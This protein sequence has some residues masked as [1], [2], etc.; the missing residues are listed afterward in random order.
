MRNALRLAIFGMLGIWINAA[1]AKE[2]KNFLIDL[3]GGDGVQVNNV[4]IHQGHFETFSLEDLSSLNDS[5]SAASQQITGG[6]AFQSVTYNVAT[7]VPVEEESLGPTL[8]ERPQTIG[9]QRLNTAASFTHVDFK[10]FKGNKLNNTNITAP[11]EDVC[12]PPGTT[13]PGGP[14][15]GG[16]D[17][18]L[19]P[20]G[21][22]CAFELDTVTL[23]IDITLKRDILA[24]YSTYGL[25][26]YWEAGIVVPLVRVTAEADSHGTSLNESG[27]H[28][29]TAGGGGDNPD[30]NSGGTKSGV[31]DVQLRTKYNFAPEAVMNLSALGQVTLPTGDEDNL[32]GSGDTEVLGL[33]IAGKKFGALDVQLN[34]GY[35]WSS[36]DFDNIHYAAGLDFQAFPTLTLSSA[37]IGRVFTQDHD[38]D[39]GNPV[40][41]G[42]GAKWDFLGGIPLA[43]SVLVPLN[44]NEGLRADYVWSVGIEQTW[45]F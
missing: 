16:P 42:V 10:R 7:G 5:L 30:D 17:G 44:G 18:Q 21:G 11:H 26:D 31:G 40:D 36:G 29:W 28:P 38:D 1:E 34:G 23:N 2:L 27:L 19:G 3:Y 39:L 8:I 24:L 25:T 14:E 37:V 32:M 41:I 15:F 33:L 20:G 22:G 35:E 4:G 9:R 6:P 45:Q 13:P 12:T 43:A